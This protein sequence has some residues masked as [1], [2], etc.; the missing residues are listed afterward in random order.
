LG[1]NNAGSS[2]LQDENPVPID[3]EAV[4]YM[5]DEMKAIDNS[6]NNRIASILSE[7]NKDIENYNPPG[8]RGGNKDKNSTKPQENFLKLAQGSMAN[9]SSLD[10]Q[11]VS[12][13]LK[14]S[15][16]GLILIFFTEF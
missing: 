14:R 1:K 12:Y 16:R 9:P 10:N 15:L 3:E 2:P 11:P 5:D 13:D 6:T 7:Y 4:D 8:K